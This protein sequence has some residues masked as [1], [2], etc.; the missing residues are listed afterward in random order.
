MKILFLHPY[1]VTPGGAGNF[2]LEIAKRLKNKGHDISIITIKVSKEI[3]KQYDLNYIEIKAPLT[4]SFLFWFR[5]PLFQIKINKILKENSGALLFPQ[6]FPSNWWGF[7]YK[8]KYKNVKCCWFC[9]EPSAFIHSKRW[10]NSI[11]NLIKVLVLKL[12]NPILKVIDVFL[13]K[14]CSDI[15]LVNSEFTKNSVKDIYKKNIKDIIY[16][17]VDMG[18]F[19]PS[20][21]KKKYF[22]IVSHI[23]AFKNIDFIIKSFSHF[24]KSNLE[25]NLEIIGEGEFEPKLK[26][27]VK[28]LKIEKNVT[29]LGK[30]SYAKLPQYYGEAK[31]LLFATKDEPFGMVPIEAMSCG[32]PIIGINSGGLKE[33]VVHN[34]TGLLVNKFSELEFSK[35][36]YCLVNDDRYHNFCKQ[37]R[38]HVKKFSWDKSADQIELYFKGMKK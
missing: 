16:P 14:K 31:A 17:G 2:V 19:Y 26:E 28:K 1:F 4:N 15:I 22:L 38:Q 3:K 8:L 18:Y 10:I 9:H 37:A 35:A 5:Y 11:P 27:L 6:I 36:M 7:F 32:T 12:F 23:S 21:N 29:F 33:T 34:K 13:V 24:L 25:Y 20:S 30:V